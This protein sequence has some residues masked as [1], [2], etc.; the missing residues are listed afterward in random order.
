MQ[1]TQGGDNEGCMGVMSYVSATYS[2][3]I[4]RSVDTTM[5]HVTAISSHIRILVTY[6][7]Q[8]LNDKKGQT[9]H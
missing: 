9:S 2:L 6:M 4:A 5:P 1:I 8:S 3:Q 7:V